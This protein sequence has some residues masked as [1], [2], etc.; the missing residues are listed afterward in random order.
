MQ[1]TIISVDQSGTAVMG[2]IQPDGDSSDAAQVVVIEAA[3]RPLV[4]GMA[5]S[6]ELDADAG[7]RGDLIAE[8]YGKV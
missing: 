7:S 8:S 2:T 6:Y 5:I 4:V 1:G 3:G